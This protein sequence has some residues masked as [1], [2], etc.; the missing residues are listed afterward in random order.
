M[1]RRSACAWSYSS[2]GPALT[3]ELGRATFNAHVLDG[4]AAHLQGTEMGNPHDGHEDLH[5][6]GNAPGEQ[7]QHGRSGEG[8]AS[9]MQHLITQ[10]EQQMRHQAMEPDTPAERPN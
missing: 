10:N 7:G 4:N 5:S 2:D 8:A 6:H 1:T 9:A 3:A